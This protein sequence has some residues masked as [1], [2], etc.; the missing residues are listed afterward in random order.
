MNFGLFIARK[1]IVGDKT[2]TH[3]VA[4][5]V[6]GISVLAITLGISVMIISFS[7]LTGFQQQITDKVIGF[8]AHIQISP[9]DNNNSFQ[10]RPVERNPDFYKF[11]KELP[12]VK[13]IQVFATKG[14][15]I[16]TQDAI[17]GIVL[18]GVANDYDWSYFE[19]KLNAGNVLQ[20]DD[21]IKNEGIV[22]SQQT[23][24]KLSLQLNDKVLIYF[25][26]QPVRV[27]KFVV[28][29]IY[30]T[31]LE[32][33]DT[34]FAFVD[35]K[36]VQKLNDWNTNQVAGFEVT[37]KDF[38]NIDQELPKIAEQVSID[39]AV[40]SIKE[41]YSQLFDWLNLQDINVV[42][43]MVMMVVVGLINMITAILIL[44]L[45]RTNMIGILK[46]LGASNWSLRKIF[47]THAAY[48]IARGILFGN[49]I[50]IGFCLL[51]QEFGFIKL[52]QSSYYM[53]QVPIDLSLSSVL[54][55]N[56]GTALV[57]TISLIL[58]TVIVTRISPVKAIK[59]S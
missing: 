45:E 21:T 6:I 32:D 51:Q 8:G 17:G 40:T 52:D 4:N 10:T 25:I 55:I 58:P 39:F 12:Q 15:I 13:N 57:C 3:K 35:I 24:D 19:T 37:L 9:Y 42:V 27:R 38:K 2:D 23:S 5:P 7:V 33:F 14:G 28:K 59:F 1:L 31:G 48:L 56:V 11:I 46:S 53:S 44:I 49:I 34:K 29:G 16:K 50:G 54:M 18:K 36:Q 22:I 47:L 30:Y 20:I 26:E 43:I 41:L